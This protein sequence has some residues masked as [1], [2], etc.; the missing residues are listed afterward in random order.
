MTDI[1]RLQ[2]GRRR[3]AVLVGL[4]AG[5]AAG[6]GGRHR[7][8]RTDRHRPPDDAQVSGHLRARADGRRRRAHLTRRARSRR[9]IGMEGGHSIDNSL[10][11][12]AHVPPARRALHDAHPLAQHARGPTPRPTRR[13]SAACRRSARRSSREM[14]WLGML[15][16]LSRTSRPTRWT[17]RS[18]CRQAPVIFS[19]S[20]ARALQRSRRAT[21]PT[22]SCR[23]CRRTAASSWSPSCPGFLSPK[24][25]GV[26]QAADRRAGPAQGSCRA[27]IAAALKAGV[28]A[29]TTAN[30][31]PARHDR[32]RRRPH[33]PHPQGRRH[34]SHRP[35]RRLRRHHADVSQGPRRRVD[36]SGLT[37]ELLRR[38]YTDDD[39]QKIL[40]L[41][42]L[43]VMRAAEKV[44]AALQKERA[45]SP[46]LFT[47]P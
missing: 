44:S 31:A 47:R 6:A 13:S 9:S 41:N 46:L 37:A 23:C 10:G 20:S 45:A 28:D 22:T 36:L 32:R 27:A 34:R 14:N 43:R 11:D 3:R 21:S 17:T 18:R 35:R 8:A 7:H 30:P 1:A 24:V 25:D 39:M 2:S 19:H 4:R 26:E 29:W 12:A 16:D 38:G 15:V 42:I 5:D 40:G 33:R